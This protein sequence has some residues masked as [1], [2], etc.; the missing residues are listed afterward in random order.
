MIL[1]PLDE[2]QRKKKRILPLSLD[3]SEE[4]EEDSY[5]YYFEWDTLTLG[6]SDEEPL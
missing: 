5:Y 4:E 2:L 3:R 6:T 1:L